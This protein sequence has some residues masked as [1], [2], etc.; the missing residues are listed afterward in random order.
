MVAQA[1]DYD[2]ATLAVPRLASEGSWCN[3]ECL[4]LLLDVTN[5]LVPHLELRDLLRAVSKQVRRVMQCDFA[6]L[7]LPDAE[8]KVLRLYTVDFPESKGDL[9][10]EV[11]YPV[12][13]S[14]S[15]AAF[16]TMKALSLQSPFG[17]PNCCEYCRRGSSNDLEA[18]ERSEQMP[19]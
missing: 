9:R 2:S 16:R 19:V 6:S 13:G 14:L 18:S 3:N 12:E 15:G 8:N 11:A 10:E 17:E 4:Q 1:H 5:Q 7:S